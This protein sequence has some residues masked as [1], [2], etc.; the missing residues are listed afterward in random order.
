MKRILVLLD[1][2][3]YQDIKPLIVKFGEVLLSNDYYIESL[4][5]DEKD[6]NLYKN[7]IDK[8][9]V[10][11]FTSNHSFENLFLFNRDFLINIPKFIVIQC[12]SSAISLD[13]KANRLLFKKIINKYKINEYEEFVLGNI[14]N[15]DSLNPTYFNAI[16]TIGKIINE[17]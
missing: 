15:V 5:F 7:F 2:S 4:M 1:K 11:I 8:D 17:G 9:I 16:E 13:Y 3:I 12:G 14:N 10:I 6:V